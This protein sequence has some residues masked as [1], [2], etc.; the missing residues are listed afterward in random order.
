MAKKFSELVANWSPE[1]TAAVRARVEEM[2][3]ET[4]LT[5]LRV[6]RDLPLDAISEVMGMSETRLRRIEHRSHLYLTA[7]RKYVEAM[8]GTLEITA[9]FPDGEIRLD[10]WRPAA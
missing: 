10:R 9:R 5:R 2:M 6:D 1:R 3:R 4:P 8:G 7:L